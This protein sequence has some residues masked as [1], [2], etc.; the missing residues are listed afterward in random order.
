[1]K[2]IVGFIMVLLIAS[3]CTCMLAQIPPQNIQVGTN[4]E[5]VLPDF[6]T[7]TYI[8]VSDNCQLKS[9]TQVP[10]PGTILNAA[11]PQVTVT[12]TA[13]DVFDNFTQV[14]FTAK[15]VDAIPPVIIPQGSLIADNWEVI[16]NMYDVAD[17]L[18]AEQ[19]SFFDVNFNWEAAG[20]PVELRPIDLYNQKVLNILT[21]PAHATTGY[22]GRFFTFLSNN[23]SYIVK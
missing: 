5:A 13:T 4:C 18:L 2:K 8:K 22:G 9:V 21:S 15:A 14:S 16:N 20:I 7:D 17:K 10:L 6:T 1:M 3:S 11:N 12:I 19:E 23:D